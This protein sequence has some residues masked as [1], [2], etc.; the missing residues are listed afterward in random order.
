MDPDDPDLPDVASRTDPEMDA[1]RRE[2]DRLFE[3][4]SREITLL[5]EVS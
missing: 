1:M 5:T 4:R 2:F 3:I